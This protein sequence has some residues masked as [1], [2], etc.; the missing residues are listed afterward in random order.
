MDLIFILSSYSQ[1][2]TLKAFSLLRSHICSW[3]DLDRIRYSAVGDL[4]LGL[5]KWLPIKSSTILPLY[6]H[7]LWFSQAPFSLRPSFLP[8]SLHVLQS[9]TRPQPSVLYL[10]VN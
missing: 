5:V 4:P 9:S 2:N 7:G 3:K 6:G 1:M 10:Q 8:C